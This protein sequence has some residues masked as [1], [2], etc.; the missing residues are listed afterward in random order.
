MGIIK[1]SKIRK[2]TI[3]ILFLFVIGL[4]LSENEIAYAAAADTP[5][6][7][8]IEQNTDENGN[9]NIT[10]TEENDKE[11]I[12]NP[13]MGDDINTIFYMSIGIGAICVIVIITIETLK[14]KRVKE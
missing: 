11:T 9:I 10:V 5:I 7:L 12:E 13:K 14:N 1:N 6:Y 8:N 2:S 4:V 3:I